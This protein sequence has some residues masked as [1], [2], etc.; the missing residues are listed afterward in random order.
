MFHV[1]Q[2]VSETQRHDH[3]AG[4]FAARLPVPTRG[5]AYLR[6]DWR[7]I[8]AF[9]SAQGLGGGLYRGL[10]QAGA[11][12]LWIASSTGKVE[13]LDTRSGHVVPLPHHA[14][15][16]GELRLTSLRQDRRRHAEGGRATGRAAGRRGGGD[17]RAGGARVSQRTRG[18]APRRTAACVGGVLKPLYLAVIFFSFAPMRRRREARRTP[19]RGGRTCEQGSAACVW[20]QRKRGRHCTSPSVIAD[21]TRT[22]RLPTT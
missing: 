12:G 10:S 17:G 21:F 1:K 19:F 22:A 9:S 3:V 15:A 8:A 2:E 6:S 5:L 18:V 11:D 14:A 13:R 16:L 20:R 7:R 4:L